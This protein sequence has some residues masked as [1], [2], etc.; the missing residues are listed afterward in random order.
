MAKPGISWMDDL[1]AGQYETENRLAAGLG[2]S[3]YTL[4]PVQKR[5]TVFFRERHSLSTFLDGGRRRGVLA[6][7]FKHTK[8][9]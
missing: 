3:A 5:R 2:G 1:C 8:N 9:L 6:E 4:H 7:G